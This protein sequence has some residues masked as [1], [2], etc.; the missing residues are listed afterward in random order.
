MPTPPPAAPPG[1]VARRRAGGEWACRLPAGAGLALGAALAAAALASDASAQS[2][3]DLVRDDYRDA[4]ETARPTLLGIARATFGV[5]AVLEIALAAL[6]WTLRER[7]PADV[8]SALVVKLGWLGFVYGLLASFDFWFVP[9]I[10][11]FVAAGQRTAV[12]PPMSPGD[13]LAVGVEISTALREGFFDEVDGLDFFTNLGLLDTAFTVLVT[14]LL[15]EIAYVLIA[16]VVV[17]TFVEAYVALTTGSLVLGFAAFRGTASLADRFVAYAF[18]VGIRLF[19]LFLLV[20][21]GQNLAEGWA[22]AIAAD[23]LN[24]AVLAE[25]LG[26]T[27]TFVLIVLVIPFRAASQLTAGF[28]PGLA[29]G[30]LAVG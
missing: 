29:R 9:V 13:I 20:G 24:K 21:I 11:G 27:L 4:V 19:L 5:L 3:L 16:A 7:G 1:P 14:S 22:L 6:W 2:A 26:G 30:L 15:I 23:P 10:D 8:L 12:G 17:L 25:V 28:D 18:A